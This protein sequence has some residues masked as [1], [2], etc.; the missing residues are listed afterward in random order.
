MQVKVLLS[1]ASEFSQSNFGNAPEVFNPV[2]V[3]VAP[4]KLIGS[5]VDSVVFLVTPI[6]QSVVAASAV[7]VDD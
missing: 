7:S 6:N 2:D 1:Q 4:G 3:V 5:M